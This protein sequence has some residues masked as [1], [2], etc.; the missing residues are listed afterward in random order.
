M[1]VHESLLAQ[2][3]LVFG[4]CD[5]GNRKG[6]SHDQVLSIY[7]VGGTN[8]NNVACMIAACHIQGN[9][10]L[11]VKLALVRKLAF[12]M[13]ISVCFAYYICEVII[14][15]TKVLQE[16]SQET[17]IN[18]SAHNLCTFKIFLYPNLVVKLSYGCPIQSQ[19]KQARLEKPS[20]IGWPNFIIVPLY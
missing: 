17:L 19:Q 4:Q 7:L 13:N 11:I 12:L 8:K 10:L 18:S 5:Q 9:I 6:T 15:S 3:Q 1:Y 14:I 16:Y 20:L 2:L